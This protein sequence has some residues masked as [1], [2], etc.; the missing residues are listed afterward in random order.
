[1]DGRKDGWKLHP[2]LGAIVSQQLMSMLYYPTSL[3]NVA[4]QQF[5][6]S[7]QCFDIFYPRKTAKGKFCTFSRGVWVWILWGKSPG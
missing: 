7:S 3:N 5:H 1:M 4:T 6:L 2:M